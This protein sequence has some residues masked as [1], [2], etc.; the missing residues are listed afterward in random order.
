MRRTKEQAAETG[1]QILAAAE[2]LFLEYGYDNVSLEDIAVAAGVT[3]GAVH[4]HFK[5]KQ[6]LSQALRDDI[7]RPFFELAETLS[8]S[9][10][11]AT[12]ERLGYVVSKM[13]ERLDSNPRQRRLTLVVMRTDITN[14]SEPG[15]SGSTFHNEMRMTLQRIFQAIDRDGGLSAAWPPHKAASMFGAM[16]GGLIMEW[17]LS[18]EDMHLSVDGSDLIRAVLAS[19]HPPATQC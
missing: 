10:G 15:Y 2:Q 7:K 11:T 8:S 5:N 4:W 17:A 1:R 6:G 19:W 18:A 3:R 13:F 12:F 16:V 14:A 9:Q